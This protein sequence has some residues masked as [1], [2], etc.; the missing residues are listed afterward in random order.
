MLDEK[1]IIYEDDSILVVNKPSGVLTVPTPA[2]EKHT[3][4]SYLNSLLKSREKP[5]A[6]F[7]CHRLDRDTSGLIIYAKSRAIQEKVMQQFKDS[8]VK[9][10]YIAFIDGIIIRPTGVIS[11]PVENKRSITKYKLLQ[12]RKDYSIIEA[13][14]ATGRTNQIRIHLKMIGHPILGER[15]YAFGKDFKVKFRRLALHAAKIQFRH[16]VDQR[17]LEFTSR[18]PDDMSRFIGGLKY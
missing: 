12:K 4:T 2:N 13:E 6:A 7:P 9:K 10:K 16:P 1:C 5:E 3:L 15:K 14:P 18:L 11:F 8:L 17:V